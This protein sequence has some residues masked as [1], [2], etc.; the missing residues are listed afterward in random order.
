MHDSMP[1]L[2]GLHRRDR[3]AQPEQIQGDR[4]KQ[5]S[6]EADISRGD[7]CVGQVGTR[8]AAGVAAQDPECQAG[9]EHPQ[10]TAEAVDYGV[11]DGVVWSM[12]RCIHRS[13]HGSEACSWPWN[14]RS[15]S[16]SLPASDDELG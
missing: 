3:H 16:V 11:G 2:V 9:V 1:H 7:P 13:S 15:G 8:G 12:T 10:P 5:E 4:P 6:T 14:P